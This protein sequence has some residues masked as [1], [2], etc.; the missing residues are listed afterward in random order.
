[1]QGLDLAV[2]TSSVL[3]VSIYFFCEADRALQIFHFP[4][5]KKQNTVKET[6]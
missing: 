1:M 5:N 6:K 4:L 3:F 2:A